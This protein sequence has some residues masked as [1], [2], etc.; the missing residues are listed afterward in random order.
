VYEPPY[1]VTTVAAKSSPT[2]SDNDRQKPRHTL[3][4]MEVAP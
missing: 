1:M 2:G 4:V 3:C